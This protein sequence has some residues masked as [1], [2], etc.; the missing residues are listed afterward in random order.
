MREDVPS[1][2]PKTLVI[3]YGNTLRCDDGAGVRVAE[4][5]AAWKLPGV[6]TLAVHQLTP[7]IA[8]TLA[9]VDLVLVVDA[10]L[11]DVDGDVAV[12]RMHA[13]SSLRPAG[14]LSDVRSLLALAEQ[15]YGR[16]PEAWLIGVPAVDFS[17][18]ETLS[19]TA[20]RGV[21]AACQHIRRMLAAAPA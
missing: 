14:H 12:S 10:Q 1:A 11:A 2:S 19:T 5:V 16:S 15:L 7:E 18:G 20:V 21:E 9:G 4:A 17:I 8:G 13:S 6:A 3:G